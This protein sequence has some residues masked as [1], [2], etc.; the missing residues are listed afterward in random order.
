VG[1]YGCFRAAPA[2]NGER[3]SPA[4]SIRIEFDR[5]LLCVIFPFDAVVMLGR[6]LDPRLRYFL[7][8]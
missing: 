8:S 3:R 6:S 7:E 2:G 5:A 4:P 1:T